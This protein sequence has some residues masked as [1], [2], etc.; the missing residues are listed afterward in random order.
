MI[1]T[2]AEPT[3]GYRDAY[4]VVTPKWGISGKY[5]LRY[6]KSKFS[7]WF[8]VF[9]WLTNGPFSFLGDLL[10]GCYISGGLDP[11]PDRKGRIW[12]FLSVEFANVGSWH[13][14]GILPWIPVLSFWRGS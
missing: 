4:S 14:R 9:F 1:V 6:S 11:V 3:P 2:K 5:G 10:S 7:L 13:T 12:E 8:V